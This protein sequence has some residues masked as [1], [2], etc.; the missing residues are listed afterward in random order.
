VVPEIVDEEV[1]ELVARDPY[2]SCRKISRNIGVSHSTV[3]R[4]L[5]S[6]LLYAF[7]IQTVQALTPNDYPLRIE[8]CQ[9]LLQR[10][11]Q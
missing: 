3:W 2:T 9:W 6:N 4:I 10:C 11:G 5:H 8:F 1:L 7:H